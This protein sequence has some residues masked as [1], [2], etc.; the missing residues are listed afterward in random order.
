MTAYDNWKADA[1]EPMD[2]AVLEGAISTVAA[3][4]V[5]DA[6][7]EDLIAVIYFA[8]PAIHELM[9]GSVLRHD[10]QR[11]FAEFERKAH[12]LIAQINNERILQSAYQERD[13]E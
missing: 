10:Y 1:P 2:P 5:A 6:E 11:D 8:G 3:K 4:L 12:G 13:D 7:L 9:G